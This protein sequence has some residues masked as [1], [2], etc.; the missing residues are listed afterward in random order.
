M[1]PIYEEISK[2]LDKDYT[3]TKVNVD[4]EKEF[5]QEFG[6]SSL[7]TII[8]LDGDEEINRN[9]GYMMPEDLKPFIQNS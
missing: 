3:F 6:V 4:E 7:P 8:I 5:A 9:V 1:G 2:E